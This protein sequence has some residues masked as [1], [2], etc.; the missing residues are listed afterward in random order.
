MASSCDGTF[1]ENCDPSRAYT[2]I[3]SVRAWHQ[4]CVDSPSLILGSQ[5]LTAQN[6]SS[7]LSFM[8]TVS[9]LKKSLGLITNGF[10]PASIGSMTMARVKNSGLWVFIHCCRQQPSHGAPLQHEWATHG[11]CYRCVDWSLLNGGNFYFYNSTLQVDCLPAGS[12][13][14]AEVRL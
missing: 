2:D 13:T 9:S 4:T 6:A 14:G 11:T 10:W 8:E 12:P 1:Q 3:S 5:L 7:T